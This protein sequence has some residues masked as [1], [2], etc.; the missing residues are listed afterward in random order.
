[1]DLKYLKRVALYLLTAVVSVFL[2]GY[3]GYHMY[4][5]F[6]TSVETITAKLSTDR[7]VISTD[8]Y[9]FRNE[10][11]LHAGQTGAVH[12]LCSNGERLQ[13]G[14]TVAD[15][16]AGDDVRDAVS[17]IDDKIA[18]LQNSG[19]TV[20][21]LADTAVIDSRITSL[22]MEILKHTG[23]KDYSYAF[24]QRNELLTLLNKR[25][26]IM[27]TTQD[28]SQQIAA[29]QEQKALLLGQETDFLESVSSASSGYF[30]DEVD[31]YETIFSANA[32]DT[33]NIGGFHDLLNTDPISYDANG[34]MTIGKVAHSYLWYLVCEI[35]QTELRTMSVNA[36]YTLTFPYNNGTEMPAK[37]Y[38]IVAEPDNDN[39][40]LIFECGTVSSNFQYLRRQAIEIVYEEYTGYQIPVLAVRMLDGVEGVFVL[41][42]SIVSFRIIK[43]LYEGEGYF[44]IEPRDASD[45]T[46]YNRLDLY[47]LVIVKGKNLYDGKII[48]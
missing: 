39:V 48:S 37:L 35:P 26:A 29:L 6:N 40:L 16:Y 8:A 23:D 28:F 24:S 32:I 9:L 18:V 21:A 30:Y 14:S 44:I 3:I 15:I 42:G 22:Y 38:R 25:Q 12:Y 33:L 45:E 17:A 11:V 31:G 41:D 43:T 27:S 20:Q 19:E 46:Q 34:G 36:T 13:A 1:M 4:I 47:D 10:T 7:E 2:I 5:S